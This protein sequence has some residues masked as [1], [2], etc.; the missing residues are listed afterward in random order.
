MLNITHALDF[1]WLASSIAALWFAM[2]SLRYSYLNFYA[3]KMLELRI[4]ILDIRLNDE[5]AGT[6]CDAALDQLANVN[7]PEIVKKRTKLYAGLVLLIPSLFRSSRNEGSIAEDG[8]VKQQ[9]VLDQQSESEQLPK[10]LQEL[11]SEGHVVMLLGLVILL[12]I[13]TLFLFGWLASVFLRV[14]VKH[15]PFGMS[16]VFETF[17]NIVQGRPPFPHVPRSTANSW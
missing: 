16:T 15:R 3:E 14:F 6:E 10:A 17:V 12:P 13:P 9:A 7:L 5:V 2:R 11:V 1:T 4:R 8:E